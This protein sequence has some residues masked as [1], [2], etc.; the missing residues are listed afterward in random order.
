MRLSFTNHSMI[1]RLAAR[2]VLMSV[3]S[4]AAVC[5]SFS[6]TF[7]GETDTVGSPQEE[8]LIKQG[9]ELRENRD[10]AGALTNF[11]RAYELTKSGRALA[12]IA[13][14]EQAL[15]RWV[16]AETHLTLALRRTEE[17]WIARNRNLLQ[18]A[19]TDIEGHT[20]ALEITGAVVGAEIFINNQRVG[21][22]PMPPVRVPAGSAALEIRAT[23]YLPLIRTVL[24][25]ARGLAREQVVLVSAHAVPQ[26]KD[27]P[28]STGT[29]SIAPEAPPRAEP[30]PPSAGWSTQ[31]KV[32]TGLA[33]GGAAALAVGILYQVI[34]EQRAGVF[35]ND[36]CHVSGGIVTGPGDCQSRYQDIQGAQKWAIGGFA[37]AA[38]LGGVG[39][40][41]ILTGA[42]ASNGAVSTR[43]AGLR[44][45]PTAA[46][47]LICAARF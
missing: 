29:Q 35:N 20:G 31:T 8:A 37:G 6:P 21:T 47:G 13:L 3:A 27:T 46:L 5:A 26:P 10:D 17:R 12:Q 33:A 19:L 9:V 4:L 18:Q 45:V 28:A 39:A 16:D 36:G 22:F 15:G 44:C 32:G 42:S 43:N 7:A 2:P 14:A 34:R 23:D 40:V 30:T 24:V 25:P 38:V 41:L 1:R 11:Q